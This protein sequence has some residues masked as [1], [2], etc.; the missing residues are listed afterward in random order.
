MDSGEY[1][2]VASSGTATVEDP[3]IYLTVI[4]GMLTWL[5]QETTA[6]SLGPNAEGKQG[7]VISLVTPVCMSVHS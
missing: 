1:L 3:P 5:W 6:R 7:H 4:P 2:C